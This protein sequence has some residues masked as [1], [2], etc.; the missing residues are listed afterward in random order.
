MSNKADK[1]IE[2]NGIDS[3]KK[4]LNI[5]ESS[6][7]SPSMKF[8]VIN[9]MWHRTSDGFT[10]FELKEAIQKH[11]YYKSIWKDTVTIPRASLEA[12]MN[13]FTEDMD[14]NYARSEDFQELF[15]HRPILE[16]VLNMKDNLN[17]KSAWDSRL[18]IRHL[19]HDDYMKAIKM[20]AIEWVFET[21]QDTDNYDS[22]CKALNG[23]DLIFSTKI[24]GFL[25]ENNFSFDK[26]DVS[27]EKSFLACLQQYLINHPE[28]KTIVDEISKQCLALPIN[29]DVSGFS[30]EYIE[31]LKAEMTDISKSHVNSVIQ[32]P[33][34][35]SDVAEAVLFTA[36]SMLQESGEPMKFKIGEKIR[37]MGVT[38]DS[39]QPLIFE[40]VGYKTLNNQVRYILK[41]ELGVERLY[42]GNNFALVDSKD[43][44]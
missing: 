38:G 41:D 2:D 5:L 19:T 4:L 17:M 25:K 13:W 20:T 35:T 3:A 36:M 42:Y 18:F 29:I 12:A 10:Y 32:I 43:T 40:V 14:C 27:I 8:G 22:L 30:K 39:P 9:G 7:C 34:K 11:D 23:A 31:K 26:Y 16:K 28:R 37:Y 6:G 44:V 33:Q 15:T 24:T 21:N 1:F